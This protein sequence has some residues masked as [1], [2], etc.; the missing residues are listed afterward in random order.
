MLTKVNL[1][2][3]TLRPTMKVFNNYESALEQKWV[4]EFKLTV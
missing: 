3:Q 4:I 1:I 2:L